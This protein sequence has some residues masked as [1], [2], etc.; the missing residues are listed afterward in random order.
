MIWDILI[1]FL[2]TIGAISI[3]I[4]TM[5][6]VAMYKYIKTKGKQ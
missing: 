5:T 3:T 1:Y 2:A 4:Y 6:V